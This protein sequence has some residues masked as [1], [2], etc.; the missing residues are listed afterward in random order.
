MPIVNRG[1]LR[2]VFA[3]LLAGVLAAL[4][5]APAQAAAY[6]YW[7]FYQLTD[8]AWAYAQ[9]GPDQTIPADGSVEGWRFAVGDESRHAVPR[10]VLTFD[11]LCAATPQVPA[12]SA[13]ASSS[14]SAAPP[15]P[16]RLPPRPSPRRSAPCADQRDE[17]R[18]AR[19]GGRAAH[20]KG[21]I[22]AVAGYPATGCGGEVKEVGARRRPPTPRSI[23]AP[24]AATPATPA[25]VATRSRPSPSASTSSGRH[26]GGLRHRRSR[27]LAI[28]AYLI[29]R[30]RGRR[31]LL[32]EAT[33]VQLRQR[34]LHPAAWWL[35]GWV[36]RRPLAHDQP[37]R[38]AARHR[39][40]HRRG[41]GASDPATTNPLWGFL[42]IG[43]VIIAFR[44]AM[45]MLL[46]NGVYGDTVLFTLPQVP[47]RSGLPACRIGGPVTLESLSMPSMTVCASPRSSRASGGNALAS[48]RRLLRYLP[49]RSTTSAPPSSSVS[50][51]RR[52]C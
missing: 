33:G 12:T 7:G 28:I 10:A 18:R 17:H 11:A 6:R 26:R 47:R 38:A 21:L 49:P 23:T 40:L 32:T 35:W 24:A 45:T 31:A 51:S 44:V 29:A 36:S 5:I 1:P 19:A 14:T 15:M 8:G 27:P 4:T 9:K 2:V 25:A 13:S 30:S 43:A 41:H 50:P 20:R 48:P 52:S 46:G 3:L 16:R 37:R 39:C 34:L 42:V 22:C